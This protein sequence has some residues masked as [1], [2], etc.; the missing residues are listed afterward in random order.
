MF[1]DKEKEIQTSKK[2]ISNG[3]ELDD[4]KH[5]LRL[6]PDETDWDDEILRKISAAITAAENYCDHHFSLTEYEFKRYNFNDTEW[7]IRKS[8]F[9]E[10][11]SI[12]SSDDD[13][14]FTDIS[15]SVTVE[16]GESFFT[17]HF[18]GGIDTTVVKIK[19]RVGF[20]ERSLLDDASDAYEAIVVKASDMYDTE[21]SSYAQKE[22]NQKVFE[23]LLGSYQNRRW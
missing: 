22:K 19:F 12:E 7:K 8:P 17:I 15:S 3:I 6:S 9:N 11:V 16:E 2:R 1:N 13:V 5:N 18:E 21:R 4:V 10:L 20:S 23:T 14:S